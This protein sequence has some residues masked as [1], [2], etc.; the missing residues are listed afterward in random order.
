[1][2]ASTVWGE[3]P[4]LLRVNKRLGNAGDRTRDGDLVGH[5][6]V[7]PR[8]RAAR[9][10]DGFAHPLK[11]RQAGRKGLLRTARHY[12]K[13]GV[14]P[15]RRPPG[16]GRVYAGY[17]ARLRRLENMLRQAWAARRHIDEI[18]ARPRGLNQT[19]AAQIYRFDVPRGAYDGNAGVRVTRAVRR[20]LPPLRAALNE[21]LRL[22][23]RSV[24][25]PERIPGVHQVPGHS[26]THYP[27]AYE[28]DLAHIP[29]PSFVR[30]A[31][32]ITTAS[33]R[34]RKWLFQ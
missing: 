9:E 32:G 6:R 18:C 7:L 21:R 22:F 17:A 30:T 29:S 34:R 26:R 5:F 23:L 8:A 1:M 20:G 28:S 25:H 13:S 24:I 4:H 14:F 12:G 15:R 27:G 19:V 11:Q 2:Q 31:D 33:L 16:Y 10:R 3:K